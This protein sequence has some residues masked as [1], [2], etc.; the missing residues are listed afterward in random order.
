MTSRKGGGREKRRQGW[1]I[2]DM[3]G[4]DTAGRQQE[5]GEGIKQ[6]PQRLALQPQSESR[7]H[8]HPRRSKS[9]TR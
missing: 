1:D 4:G 7:T 3:E 5:E 9:L 2:W 6:T 8:V